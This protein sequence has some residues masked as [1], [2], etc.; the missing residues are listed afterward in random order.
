[1]EDLR[2]GLA[3]LPELR[4]ARASLVAHVEEEDHGPTAEIAPGVDVTTAAGRENERR[5]E[6]ALLDTARPQLDVPEPGDQE[7]GRGQ[8]QPAPRRV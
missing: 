5:G 2:Q 3:Q 1:M 8:P 6:G 4:P 7:D